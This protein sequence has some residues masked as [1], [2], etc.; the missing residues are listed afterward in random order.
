[1]KEMAWIR[2]KIMSCWAE[3][4]QLSEKSWGSKTALMSDPTYTF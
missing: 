2:V 1:M 4:N 3:N